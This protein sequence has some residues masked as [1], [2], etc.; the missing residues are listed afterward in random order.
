[1]AGGMLA[2]VLCFAQ[3]SPVRA[4]GAADGVDNGANATQAA[5]Q[6]SNAASTSRHSALFENLNLFVGP[7]GSKQPQDLGINANMGLRVSANWAFP[8][9]QR[10]SIG[11][12]VGAASNLSDAAVHV[13]D[14]IE[15]T[16]RRTQSFVTVGMFHREDRV[17]A[18]L[19]YD[20]MIEKYF[21]NFRLSQL[22]GQAGYTLTATNEIGTWFTKAVWGDNGF[23][24]GS[25]VRLDPISQVNVYARHTWSNFAQT[26]LWVGVA[27]GH[28]DVVWVLPDN[29]RDNHVLVYGSEL[30]MPLSEKFAI[31]GAANFITPTATGTVDAYLGL[32][33]YPGHSALR[34]AR[35]RYAPFASVANNPTFAVNLQR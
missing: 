12:Q 18:G 17:N 33:F 14:Q 8:V 20:L 21:D 3:S 35:G 16:S 10:F 11:G 22:R 9:V 15:G 6:K 7:D 1:M 31:T 23:M 26:S 13:L 5:D 34:A 30:N 28:Q 29:S 24:A 2:G 4:E 32:T 19:A 25:P 27:S